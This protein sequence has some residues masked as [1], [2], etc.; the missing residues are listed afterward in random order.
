MARFNPLHYLEAATGKLSSSTYLV[1]PKWLNANLPNV[2]VLDGSWYLPTAKRD[3]AAEYHAGPRIPG[4]RFFDIDGIADKSTNLPHMLP[5][6]DQFAQA[7]SRLGVSHEK[8]IVVYDNSGLFSAA[9]VW[10]T[11]RCFGHKQ[12]A[13]L[14]GGMPAFKAE[15]F[16]VEAG[17][18]SEHL[19]IAEEAWA[20]DNK[21]VRSLSDVLA[22]ISAW[23][24]GDEPA[25]SL[26]VDARPGPRFTG[27]APEPRPGLPSGHI[28]HSRSVPATNLLDLSNHNRLL[29]EADIRK[30]FAAAGA[31]V[32]YSEGDIITSCGSGVTASILY[33]ALAMCGRPTERMGLYDG[34]WTEYAGKDSTVKTAGPA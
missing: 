28:P 24:R 30:I 8:P 5:P 32:D 13:V 20:L 4:A 33:L 14:D 21:V 25:T 17:A 22:N 9:R 18:A 11:L 19:P 3:P 27:E 16:P 12:A 23:E 1:S 2:T 34:A 26:V 31:P 29:P 10:W 15:G 7:M 6:A